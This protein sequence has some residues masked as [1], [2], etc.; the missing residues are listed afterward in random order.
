MISYRICLQILIIIFYC[1]YLAR[2]TRSTL[3]ETFQTA[4]AV[5][6]SQCSPGSKIP[7]LPPVYELVVLRFTST[8]PLK[9]EADSVYLVCQKPV[10]HHLFLLRDICTCVL[11]RCNHNSKTQ[12]IKYF[13]SICNR[14]VVQFSRWFRHLVNEEL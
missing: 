6:T 10:S 11:T 3:K 8:F 5:S 4:A 14:K 12:L 7:V 13:H 9:P 2:R 1:Y